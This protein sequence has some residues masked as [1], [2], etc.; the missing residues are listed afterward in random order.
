MWV[1]CHPPWSVSP[2]GR[3]GRAPRHTGS[4]RR[5]CR[6]RDCRAACGPWPPCPRRP[7][8]QVC[9]VRGDQ[10]LSGA[11]MWPPDVIA[12]QLESL[13]GQGVRQHV[14]LVSG[15]VGLYSVHH[16]VNAWKID[17][18]FCILYLCSNLWRL[19]LRAAESGW[20][21]HPGQRSQRRA[22]DPQHLSS[23]PGRW[24]WRW[25]WS[26]RSRCR[27]WWAPGVHRIVNVVLL[28]SGDVTWIRGSLRPL[29]SPTPYTS[30]RDCW[31][32]PH[33]KAATWRVCTI[34]IVSII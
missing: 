28:T 9:N 5:R 22:G 3:P 2:G 7:G 31:V 18:I 20:G 15:G 17:F 12:E 14:L 24:W 1:T 6:R 23:P 21:H 16:R 26:P 11:M 4:W 19:W 29:V 30:A 8:K 34:V 10:W 13:P 27:R 33:M 25:C 32:S